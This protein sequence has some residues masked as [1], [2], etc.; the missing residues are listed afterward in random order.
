VTSGIEDCNGYLS[1]LPAWPLMVAMVPKA[2]LRS[3]KLIV[4]RL[5]QVKFV[6]DVDV[7]ALN[8][9]S[10]NTDQGV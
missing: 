5:E 3:S 6:K 4:K 1:G 8:D 2:C 10:C 7:M 9:P